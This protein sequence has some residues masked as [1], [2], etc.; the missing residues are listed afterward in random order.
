M[1]TERQ[2]YWQEIIETQAASGLN[3]ADFFKRNN[4]NPATYYY[5]FKKINSE[6][7]TNQNNIL[8]INIAPL[9]LIS[10]QQTVELT[11]P[12]GYQLS[13]DASIEPINLKQVLSVLNS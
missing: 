2:A 12:N 11:L 6:E 4:I 3:K 13:F 5:W 9:P 1:A 8:P 7:K 10:S